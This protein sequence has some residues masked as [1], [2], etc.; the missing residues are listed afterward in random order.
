MVQY[1]DKFR[2][3]GLI[4]SFPI[5][6]SKINLKYKLTVTVDE[7]YV[8]EMEGTRDIT[9]DYFS[10]SMYFLYKTELNSKLEF[11]VKVSIKNLY[12]LNGDQIQ[13]EKWINHNVV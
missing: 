12:D 13:R 6:I 8:C 10:F 1:L 7:K 5:N 3:G 4:L 9:N 11:D 2:I